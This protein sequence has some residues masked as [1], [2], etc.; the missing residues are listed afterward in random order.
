MSF[1]SVELGPQSTRSRNGA[2]D[3]LGVIFRLG[4]ADIALLRHPS[5]TGASRTFP[6]RI[7]Q[8]RR[9]S[10]HGTNGNIRSLACGSVHNSG[11]MSSV[12]RDRT[13]RDE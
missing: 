4:V 5:Q 10:T 6:D 11:R 13:I 7:T 12:A 2:S 8:A 3:V 9:S 1:I